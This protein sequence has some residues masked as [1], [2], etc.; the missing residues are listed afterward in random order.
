MI[1]TEELFKLIENYIFAFPS[2]EELIKVVFNDDIETFTKMRE[3]KI[4]E[5]VNK[6][7][8]EYFKKQFEEDKLIEIIKKYIESKGKALSKKDMMFLDE[9]IILSGYEITY[10]EIE[11]LLEIKEIVVYVNNTKK[12]ETFLVEQIKEFQELQEFEKE[13]EEETP[14]KKNYEGEDIVEK[15]YSDISNYDLLTEEEEKYYIKRFQTEG[16]PE[17]FEILV[18]SNQGLCQKVARA[19]KNRGLS[20]LDLVQEGNIGLMKALERFDLNRKTKLSTY[21][22]WWIRQAV[23]RALYENSKTIRL[24]MHIIE[25]QEKIS[26]A[27]ESFCAENG[28]EPNI[29]E[30]QQLTGLTEK[31]IKDALKADIKMVSFEKP[32]NEEES[33]ASEFGDFVTSEDIETPH[34]LADKEA[35]HEAYELLFR[36]L[37]ED[38]LIPQAA[39]T[40]QII[41]LRMGIEVYNEVTYKIIKSCGLPL[42]DK[43]TLEDV[44]KIFGRT[45]ERIRQLQKKGIDRMTVLAAKYN[46]DIF[47][48]E[49]YK[50]M[51]KKRI[52]KITEEQNKDEE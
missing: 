22:M 33:D 2:K 42:K 23:R 37:R 44:G 34:E 39:R 12:D 43:Y 7:L 29:E 9:I 49:K 16:D 19:F 24:P 38:S 36:L 40:E 20:F 48:N 46:I 26:K 18:G 31:K 13:D 32:V 8:S 5:K 25:A 27:S 41:R 30:L 4:E 14:H 11:K 1:S 3:E 51:V 47:E 35:E 28:R 17:A 52:Q 21:A 45:R 50:S 15:Y 10:E 6:N